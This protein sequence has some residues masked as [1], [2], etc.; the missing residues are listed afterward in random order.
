L[1]GLVQPVRVLGTRVTRGFLICVRSQAA[2]SAYIAI[3]GTSSLVT[4]KIL[5]EK[6][7]HGTLNFH[8][9]KSFQDHCPGWV[10]GR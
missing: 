10:P 7:V 9:E 6:R 1:T 3:S 4:A 8:Q 2:L 5:E